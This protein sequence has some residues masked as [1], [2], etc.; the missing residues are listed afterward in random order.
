M[1]VSHMQQFGVAL[2]YLQHTL[3]DRQLQQLSKHLSSR[4][5]A[6][7]FTPQVQTSVKASWTEAGTN[8]SGFEH[9]PHSHLNRQWGKL[10]RHLLAQLRRLI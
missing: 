10:L 1:N 9:S 6:L 7:D 8:G 4:Y 5:D 2:A 3:R